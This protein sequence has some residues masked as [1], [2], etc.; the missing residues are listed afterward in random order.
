MTEAHRVN[1]QILKNHGE[2]IGHREKRQFSVLS[3][4]NYLCVLSV[5]PVA[6]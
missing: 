1:L 4:V 3:V 2:Y 6:R 5:I